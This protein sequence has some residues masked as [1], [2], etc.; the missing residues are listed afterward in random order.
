MTDKTDPLNA[1]T[2]PRPAV[3]DN[4]RDTLG[5]LALGI[6]RWAADEDGVPDHIYDDLAFAH[7]LLGWA[8]APESPASKP[9]QTVPDSDLQIAQAGIDEIAADM[10][11]ISGRCSHID[12][13]IGAIRRVLASLSAVPTPESSEARREGWRPIESAP[14]DESIFVWCRV[15][16]RYIGYQERIADTEATQWCDWKG[17]KGLLPPVCWQPLPEPPTPAAQEGG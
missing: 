10:E 5:N 15:W 2:A 13:R 4:W 8:F 17:D 11:A 12:P 16:G 3:P 6:R 7:S 14:V 1:S 9:S